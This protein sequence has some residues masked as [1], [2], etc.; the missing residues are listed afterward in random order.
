MFLFESWVGQR[1]EEEAKVDIQT[2]VIGRHK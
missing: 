1:E 2:E